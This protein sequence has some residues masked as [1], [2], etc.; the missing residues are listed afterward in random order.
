MVNARHIKN[1]PGR[2]PDVQDSKRLCRLLRNG[3]EIIN[4]LIK[5]ELTI[6]EMSALAKGK[7]KKKADHLSSWA[8][9]SPGNKGTLQ[10]T[11]DG[12]P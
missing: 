6:E 5:G 9:M 7:L 10:R 8:G 2:K 4:E 12:L 1:A 3:R 11:G